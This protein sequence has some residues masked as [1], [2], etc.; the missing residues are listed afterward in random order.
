MFKKYLLVIGVI[1]LFLLS[2]CQIYED[3]YGKSDVSTI[4]M[5]DIVVEGEE[6]EEVAEEEEEVEEEEE[7]TS[8][9]DIF[10][11]DEEEEEEV[12]EDIEEVIEIIEEE[13]EVVLE[14]VDVVDQQAVV[15][16]VEETELVSLEPDATDPDGD[17]LTYAFTSPLDGIGDWQ[18]TY[19]D[20]GEYTVTITASD[21][22]LSASQDVLIIVNRKEEAPIIEFANPADTE[23]IIAEDN[24]IEF[25]VSASDLNGDYLD[26]EWKID[27]E[28]V[29]TDT[30]FAFDLG[31]DSAGSHT[32][33]LS[34]TD[35]TLE[36]SQI[37]AITVENVNRPPEMEELDNIIVN[38]NEPV[39]IVVE[40]SDLDGDGLSF[41][42]DSDK[43]EQ[44]GN[45]FAWDTT[46]DD[47]GSYDVTITVSD[48]DLSVSQ[49]I[50][51]AVEN[52]NRAPV[53]LGIEQR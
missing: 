39:I 40:A 28:E 26:Y 43:F 1:V 48:G 32:I 42:A 35:G 17:P 24:I 10:R 34:I 27:G 50:N 36:T 12:E 33:K 30:S 6:D 21:G 7:R 38:E 11:R 3:I 23:L 46:Y 37:W 18:T 31:Y 25:S 20:E 22:D 15:I 53:F 49:Q 4:S 14:D 41:A 44:E 13:E 47:S 2:G 51:V 8:P 5:D 16:I 45:V 29:S 52:V 19:G 9:L